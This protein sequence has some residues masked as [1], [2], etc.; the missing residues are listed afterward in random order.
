MLVTA[1]ATGDV[2]SLSEIRQIVRQ[3]FETR[4]Y[5]PRDPSPW[6][7]AYGRYKSLLPR[8]KTQ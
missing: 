4:H 5:A 7:D 2:K 3:S 1:M 8:Q 6:D